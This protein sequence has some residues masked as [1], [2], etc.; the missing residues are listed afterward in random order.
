MIQLLYIAFSHQIQEPRKGGSMTLTRVGL[1][2]L[3]PGKEPGFDH[4]DVYRAQPST[5]RLY[6]S[7]TAADRIEVIDCV[8]NTYLPPLPD[9][10]GVA[11]ILI[12]NEQDL[13]FSS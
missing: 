7:H 5:V 10:P 8:S 1:I 13:L 2:P 6:V 12:D 9:L 4:A 3:P 11:G